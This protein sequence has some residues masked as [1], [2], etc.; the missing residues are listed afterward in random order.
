[1]FKNR[2]AIKLTSY[3][4]AALLVFSIIIGSVFIVL[5]RN[6]TIKLHKAELEKRA[7]SIS[8]TLSGFMLSNSGGRMYGYGVYLRLINDIALSDT[9]IVDENLELITNGQNM[10]GMG[11]KYEYSDLPKGADS[12]I[13]EV[14]KGKT[15]F[16]ES[17]S[18]LLKV[19]TITVGS[20]I[21][22]Q[23]NEVIGAV[24]LHSPVE[25][26]NQASSAGINILA[27]SIFV[28]L[29][30]AFFLSIGFSIT[31]TKPLNKM[32]N[33]AMLLAKG[34]YTALTNIKQKDEIGE[35]AATI[36][37]LTKRLYEASKESEKLEKL[38]RD[39]VANISHELRT[40]ITVMRGSLEALCDEIVTD[41]K[42]VKS[43]HEQMLFEAKFLQRLVGDL[44]DLSKLQNT[45]FVI[46][47]QTINIC[48]VIE[49]VK[50]SM[51]HIG[52]KKGVSI[53][54]YNDNSLC[55]I[56]A[57]YG[58]LRQMLMILVDNAL[59]FSPANGIVRID[60]KNKILSITD[61]GI[62]IPKE[63]LPYIFDRFNKSRSEQNKSGTGLGL[64]IAKQIA[65]RH[66]IVISVQSE[67]N[68]KTQFTLEFRD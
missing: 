51:S 14:F 30:I 55:E 58:R 12:V 7:S 54:V 64:A 46:E 25:G 19:P 11:K 2:I 42:L 62:G 43:Y 15:V 6:H 50:R 16:S 20:P 35:L 24:L 4:T 56:V 59:K 47:K 37:I 32:K 60:L 26:V 1:M 53:E 66:D 10:R 5:F 52:D 23:N 38:R 18:S 36:D 31:F 13:S 34:D 22:D 27:I 9:W 65:E 29:L 41:P 33:T 21:L 48:H 28:A 39:F 57:D 67:E 8:N 40:P 45:D 68:V 3:F 44:L 63:N 17:F 49:D 61:N